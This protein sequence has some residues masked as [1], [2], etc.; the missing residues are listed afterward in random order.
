MEKI[1]A[2]LTGERIYGERL[3]AYANHRRNMPFTAVSFDSGAAYR[4]FAS[5]HK[6]GVLLT[7]GHLEKGCFGVRDSPPGQQEELIIGLFDET[8]DDSVFNYSEGPGLETYTL[9]PKYQS[10]EK[11]M[12]SVM[13][14]CS[15]MGVELGRELPKEKPY[16]AGVYSPDPGA[17]KSAYALTLSKVL[18]LKKKTL[19]ISFEEFSG[20]SQVTGDSYGVSLSD[21]F[22][23]LKQGRLDAERICSLVHI[24]SGIEYIPPVQFAD[25][26][27]DVSGGDCAALM[28]E[29][30][31]N[32]SYGAIVIDLP[33]IFHMAEEM[34]DICDEIFLPERSDLLGKAKVEEF[35]DYLEFSKKLRLKNRMTRFEL[36]ASLSGTGAAASYLDRLL[37]GEFGDRARAHAEHIR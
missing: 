31:K 10:A 8:D 15:A 9:I 32:G 30:I 21:G 13:S 18:S 28:A 36:E 14:C 20:F 12:R 3:C 33:K 7:D 35:M 1:M 27:K 26:M 4:N 17:P 6:I 5:K 37:Y 23:S 2:V 29:I 16:V 34:M 11:I 24:Y 22:L 25:D 19:F